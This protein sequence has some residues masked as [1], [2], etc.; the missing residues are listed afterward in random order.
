ME[1]QEELENE[2][3]DDKEEANLAQMALTLSESESEASSNLD[4]EDTKEVFSEL[5]K[6]N[7]ITLCQDLMERCQQKARHMKIL[8]KQCG[9]VRDELILS[10]DK[11]E[12]L[13]RDKKIFNTRYV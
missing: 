4:P 10:K 12:K 8:K 11:I 3:E 7:L 9:L 1:T 2:E 5:F 13:V 6:S